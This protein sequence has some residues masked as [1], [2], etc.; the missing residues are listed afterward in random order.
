MLAKRIACTARKYRI[1]AT[2]GSDPVSVPLT[3][4][5]SHKPLTIRIYSRS[6]LGSIE[7]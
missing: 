3:S 2:T 7:R 4:D 1:L 5:E 6:P